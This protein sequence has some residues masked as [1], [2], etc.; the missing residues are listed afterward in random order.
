[1]SSL[2]LSSE[3]HIEPPFSWPR[4]YVVLQSLVGIMFTCTVLGKPA[5]KLF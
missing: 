5:F 1:M 3:N 4:Y 2:V